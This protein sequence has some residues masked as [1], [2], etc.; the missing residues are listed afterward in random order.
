MSLDESTA[1][2]LEEMLNTEVDANLLKTAFTQFFK[3]GGTIPSAL[4]IVSDQVLG[5]TQKIVQTLA[6]S[7]TETELEQKYIQTKKALLETSKWLESTLHV[8]HTLFPKAPLSLELEEKRKAT[9]AFC[10]SLVRALDQYLPQVLAA[11]KKRLTANFAQAKEKLLFHM[12]KALFTDFETNKVVSL[13]S[14]QTGQLTYQKTLRRLD[15]AID[16]ITAERDAWEK[17][18]LSQMRSLYIMN[19]AKFPHA[20]LYSLRGNIYVVQDIVEH[21]VGI[22]TGKY[23][24][25]TFDLETGSAYA[26]T[27][28]RTIKNP[29]TVEDQAQ[30]KQGNLER[31]WREA[32][33]LKKLQGRIG[34]IQLVDLF[35]FTSP[36][37]IKFFEITELLMKQNLYDLLDPKAPALSKEDEIAIALDLL[38]G[39]HAMAEAHIIHRDIK[40]DNIL[41]R[42][43]SPFSKTTAH[44][45]DFNAACFFHEEKYR[46]LFDCTPL[47]CPPELTSILIESDLHST[48]KLIPLVTPKVDVWMTGCVLY[49][50][51]FKERHPFGE[52]N[53]SIPE[54]ENAMHFFHIIQKLSEDWIDPKY[55]THPMFPLIKSMLVIDP[56]KRIEAKEALALCK[57]ISTHYLP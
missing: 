31:A 33:F 13:Q 48:K 5:P 7:P 4:D 27:M 8:Y 23:V 34:I 55:H 42:L 50:L 25:R 16:L 3:E 17:Q 28:P 51:F 24:S 54:K 9:L 49:A 38:Q 39:L 41:V 37:G 53:L 21:F 12:S 2:I 20:L 35:L 6:S 19:K 56:Q 11:R 1:Y 30:F 46:A 18:A 10:D 26:L 47:V 14:F 22:G 36:S 52:N 40:L 57:K 15:A 45:I 32:L 44:I 29:N 43:Q